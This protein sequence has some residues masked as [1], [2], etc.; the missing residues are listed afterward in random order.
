MAR[1]GIDK[2]QIVTIHNP[3]D[4]GVLKALSQESLE[5]QYEKLFSQPILIAV[6][7]LIPA[8]GHWYLLRVFA[9][10][11]KKDPTVKLVILGEAASGSDLGEKLIGLSRSLGLDTYSVWDEENFH[12][13][14]DVYFMGFHQNPFKYMAASRLFAMTSVWEGFGNTI[15]EAM[16]CGT[17]VISSDCPSGPG[18]IVAPE[19]KKEGKIAQ[20]PEEAYGVLMPPFENRF[21]DADEPL[22]E[23]E[24]LWI[25]T[26]YELLHDDERLKRLSEKGLKRADDFRTEVIM[27]EWKMLIDGVLK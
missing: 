15:V 11:K 21:V 13:G 9:E 26:L 25:D 18:E 23:T 10:L 1:F 6:G 8:K 2:E 12:E 19:L 3:Y 16:A 17:P 22:S 4:I 20:K 7:R 24:K 14:H 5:L 27:K